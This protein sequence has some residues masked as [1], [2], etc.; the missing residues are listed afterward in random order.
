MSDSEEIRSV[1]DEISDGDS[2]STHREIEASWGF[3]CPMCNHMLSD[4]ADRMWDGHL[5]MSEFLE[6]YVQMRGTSET[7]DMVFRFLRNCTG[8][9]AVHINTAWDRAEHKVLGGWFSPIGKAI[10]ME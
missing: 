3:K 9:E 5:N 6:E 2:S 4:L 1:T 10:C 7:D 8:F